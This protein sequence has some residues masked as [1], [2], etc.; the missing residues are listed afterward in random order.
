LESLGASRLADAYD[1]LRELTKQYPNDAES[2]CLLGTVYGMQAKHTEAIDC[3][4]RALA[5]HAPYPEAWCNLGASQTDLGLYADAVQSFTEAVRLRPNYP[6]ALYNL[7]NV[8]RRTQHLAEAAQTYRRAL[9]FDPNFVDAYVNLGLTLADTGQ[10]DAAIEE[11]EKALRLLPNHSRTLSNLGAVY[12][13]KK[14]Y[15][16]A[17]AFYERAIAA[18]PANH[19]ARNNVAGVLLE[20]GATGAAIGQLQA[21]LAL[22]KKFPE[23]FNNLGNAYKNRGDI[24]SALRAYR[25]ACR[26]QPDYPEAQSNVL[27]TLHYDPHSSPTAICEAHREWGR[28]FEASITPLPP[29]PPRT[30]ERRLRIGYVSPDFRSHAVS[31]FTE[32]FFAN[33]RVDEF[34]TTG[35]AHV[36]APDGVTQRL[37]G[38]AAHWRH[39]YGKTDRELAQQIREDE[40]DILVD[41]AGHSGNNRLGAFA[42]RPA[43]IQLSALAYPGTTGLA[44]MDYY[45][46]DPFVDPPG[47]AGLYTEK[48]LYLPDIFACYVPPKA[49]F[50]TEPPPVHKNGFV[51]FGSFNNLAKINGRVVALWAELLKKI[52][53]ARLLV[54]AAAF[55]EASVKEN[56]LQRLETLGV[57]RSRL[58]LVGHTSF[59]EHMRL[60]NEVDIALDPFP[61]SGHTTTCNTLWMGVPVITL[62]GSRH[63][64][65]M[66]AD[67]LR[68]LDLNEWIATSPEHYVEIAEKLAGQP[69]LL[70]EYRQCMRDRIRAS[71][72][73]NTKLFTQRLEE[74]YR[75]IAGVELHPERLTRLN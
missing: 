11:Y 39:V 21:A 47:D 71:S 56:F 73:S 43:P 53:N 75:R 69:G 13:A 38:M 16:T 68:V 24:D 2:W 44:C 49:E 74:I 64:S 48:L 57:A 4:R 65:R 63:A 5:L 40:I 7:A 46:T 37:Q 41:L 55:I 20:E 45:L 72:L 27:F 62:L 1:L 6:G 15:D 28:R 26:L 35:Y 60:H 51:T 59:P 12:Q 70:K 58:R 34:E 22:Q 36:A 32:P 14:Q 10:L 50:R 33:C 19:E 31:F 17:K 67:V 29:R 42:Y 18:N 3:C 30:N 66:A 52:S 54:Q 61:W 25:E 8:H 23:A 9:S